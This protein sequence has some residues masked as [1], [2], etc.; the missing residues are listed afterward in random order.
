MKLLIAA[1]LAVAPTIAHAQTLELICYGTSSWV[2][3]SRGNVTSDDG[4]GTRTDSTVTM[5]DRRQAAGAVH[6][7]VQDDS[8]GEIKIPS[9]LIP[10]LRSSSKDGWRPFT[11]LALSENEIRGRFVLN[12][13]NKPKL[14][15]DRRTGDL[16]LTGYGLAFRGNCDKAPDASAPKKF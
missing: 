11:E 13:I 3:E 7:R 12:V 8:L 2:S 4:W 1:A 9:E 14:V 10:P 6:I 15:V 16:E 5:S